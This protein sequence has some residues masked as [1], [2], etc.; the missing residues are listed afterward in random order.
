MCREWRAFRRPFTYERRLLSRPMLLFATILCGFGRSAMHTLRPKHIHREKV[1]RLFFHERLEGC[2]EAHRV[3]YGHYLDLPQKCQT[4]YAT[5]QVKFLL[6]GKDL[7]GTE[8]H[9]SRRHAVE[10]HSGTP[11]NRDCSLFKCVR[12]DH[13]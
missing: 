10:P 2:S 3:K 7:R 6:Q 9:Y 8:S 5:T 13:S 12:W 4:H 1:K 11:V